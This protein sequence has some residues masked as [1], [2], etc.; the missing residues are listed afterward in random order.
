MRRL[1]ALAV[2]FLSLFVYVPP[3]ACG[4]L[5]EARYRSSD[6][7]EMTARFNLPDQKVVVIPPGRKEITLPLAESASGARYSN[8]R[9]T[10]W[11]HKSIGRFLVDDDVVFEGA[12]VDDQDRQMKGP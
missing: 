6:G 9:E 7:K 3:A 5:V 10:F 12:L 11:E 2:L 8:G 1:P 4:E